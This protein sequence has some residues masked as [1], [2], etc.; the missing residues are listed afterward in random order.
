MYDRAAAVAAADSA[1]V[2]A[3]S[4]MTA[5]GAS[6]LAKPI[7]TLDTKSSPELA[8]SSAAA[9]RCDPGMSDREIGSDPVGSSVSVIFQGRPS[10]GSVG[11]SHRSTGTTTKRRYGFDGDTFRAS[12]GVTSYRLKTGPGYSSREPQVDKYPIQ[13]DT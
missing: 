4:K 7:V 12:L 8:E 9:H 5:F 6:A 1:D 13:E 10:S 2:I 11:G 3:A